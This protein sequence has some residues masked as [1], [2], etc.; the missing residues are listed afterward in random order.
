MVEQ[1]I[2]NYVDLIRATIHSQC[3]ENGFIT[4]LVMKVDTSKAAMS[5]PVEEYCR[6][7]HSN[8]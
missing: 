7:C 1:G 5:R 8:F 2:Y 3:L 6:Q 4:T